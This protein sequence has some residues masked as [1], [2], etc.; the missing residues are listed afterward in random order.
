PLSA[1][2]VDIC[3]VGALTDRDFRFKVRVWYLEKTPS[4]CPGCSTG[5]NIS[6]EAY[7]NRIARFKPRVNE[8]VNSHWICDEGR[9]CFH[10]LA[11]GERLTTPMIRQEGGL[12]PTTWEQALQAAAI[13]LS[14]GKPLAAI[15]SGRNTNEEAFL[16]AK[17]INKIAPDAALEVFYRER[18]LTETQKIL[19]SPDRSPNF[20]GA[21]DMGVKSNG[22]FAALMNK[23]ATDSYASALVVGEDLIGAN[24]DGANIRVALKKLSFLV[25]QDTRMTETAKLAHVVL[26]AAHFGE[27]EGSYTN[28]AGRV[29]RLNA[30]VIAP[31]G[32]LQDSEIFLRLLDALGAA[33]AYSTPAE[34]FAAITREVAG[35][36]GLD[37]DSIGTLGAELASGG[38]AVS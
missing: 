23:L 25:V 15:L 22:G 24:G 1:N 27:K 30:A 11:G 3:P 20:R 9:Y 10:D 26:P 21:R 35:Y 29:Q 4:I 28:R 31:E 38:G 19:M 13:G 32:A 8:A 7:Q 12:V 18:A 33:Q 14:G 5:C 6:V 16:F 34:V 2:V 36:Q 37:Y 17:L